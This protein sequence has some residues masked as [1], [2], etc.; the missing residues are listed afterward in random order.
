[1]LRNSLP[2]ALKVAGQPEAQDDADGVPFNGLADPK[3]PTKSAPSGNIIPQFINY[4]DSVSLDESAR[5]RVRVQ[6]MRDYHRRRA[7]RE[8]GREEALIANTRDRKPPSAKSQI[9]KFRLGH[10]KVLRPWVPV[11][12][13]ASKRMN[14]ST[15]GERA[16]KKA[17]RATQNQPSQNVQSPW[18]E[19]EKG[20]NPES[21]S[22]MVG[23]TAQGQDGQAT[24]EPLDQWLSLLKL[25]LQSS[26]LHNSLDSGSL[27][28]FSTTALLITPRTQL[29][30]HHYCKLS[31]GYPPAGIQNSIIFWIL[32][33]P[34]V[35]STSASN[36]P[37]S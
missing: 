2:G 10:E 21:P 26:V 28:P 37:G 35:Q 30:L 20:I 23:G 16:S 7:Q 29:L 32:T 15:A 24:Q 3:S 33:W 12:T 17:V 34:I 5:T 13:P 4:T 8:E 36:P 14:G 19:N 9:Q 22:A 6:V 27:D 1:M 11:K 25:A 31:T 18:P